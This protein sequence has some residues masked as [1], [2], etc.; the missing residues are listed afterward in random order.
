MT[1]RSHLGLPQAVRAWFC[2]SAPTKFVK[3][4]S[5]DE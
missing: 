4:D 3:E 5:A 2:A 1:R